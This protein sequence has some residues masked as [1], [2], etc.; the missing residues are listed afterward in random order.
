VSLERSSQAQASATA[1]FLAMDP[2]RHDQMRAL[3]SR[4]FTPRR[5]ADLEER[6]R[7]LTAGYVDAFV[8]A[9]DAI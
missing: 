1:S 8:R 9:G 6:V 5:V 3:V 7:V 4:G 2:P